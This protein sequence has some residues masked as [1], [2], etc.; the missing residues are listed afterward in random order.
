M[1]LTG[2]ST[3]AVFHAPRLKSVVFRAV[4][5]A[6]KGNGSALSV[7]LADGVGTALESIRYGRQG[8]EMPGSKKNFDFTLCAHASP[9]SRTQ[10]SQ[11]PVSPYAF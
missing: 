2:F 11:R 1:G 10:T 7:P 8:R 6:V 4:P 5:C 9:I 3:N